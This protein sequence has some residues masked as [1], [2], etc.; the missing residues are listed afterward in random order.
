MAQ[1]RLCHVEEKSEADGLDLLLDIYGETNPKTEVLT[2]YSWILVLQ[3]NRDFSFLDEVSVVFSFD[4]KDKAL[5]KIERCMPTS[6][7]SELGDLQVSTPYIS[8]ISYT[9]P[10]E[11]DKI[12]CRI[13]ADQIKWEFKDINLAKDNRF[14]F[15]IPGTVEV[16]FFPNAHDKEFKLSMEV[17]PK[18]QKS[19]W[20][21]TRRE[22]CQNPPKIK[23]HKVLEVCEKI[24]PYDPIIGTLSESGKE[25]ILNYDY[26]IE[27]GVL[28][29][30]GVRNVALRAET[31]SRLFDKISR[32]LPD[33]GNVIK[34]AGKEIGKNFMS[35]FNS[36]IF[37]R[38][39]ELKEKIAMWIDYDSSAGIGRFEF[40]DEIKTI[41][42]HSSFN[43]YSCHHT[44]PVCHFLAGYFEG[45]LS[46][47]LKESISV[48]E[49]QCIATGDDVCCFE[50][51]RTRK[52]SGKRKNKK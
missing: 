43:A 29:K 42:V 2:T 35:E 1:N 21:G 48:H 12:I 38:D 51:R 22:P 44:E 40:D 23:P 5:L 9:H 11:K 49:T 7:T 39:V 3:G 37:T 13:E 41:K 27:Q 46:I 10:I 14:K 33:S 31:L 16:I 17:S 52:L 30:G 34:E 47:L 36:A 19:T 6:E 45:A 28:M 50:I 15:P 4:K 26:I 8:I 32:D 25:R 24:V 18:F 20:L